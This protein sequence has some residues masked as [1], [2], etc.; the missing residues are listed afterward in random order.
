MTQSGESTHRRAGRPRKNDPGGGAPD[1]KL[2]FHLGLRLAGERGEQIK[3]L[4]ALANERA[5]AAGIPANVSASS[6]V[7]MW[8]TERIGQEMT[9]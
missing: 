1:T 4:V 3:K 9:K 8:I 6:L 7:T 5:R 2:G